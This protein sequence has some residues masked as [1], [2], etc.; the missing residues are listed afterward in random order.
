MNQCV[1]SKCFSGAITLSVGA[2]FITVTC[3]SGGG[4]SCNKSGVTVPNPASFGG[5]IIIYIGMFFTLAAIVVCAIIS[6]R[7]RRLAATGELTKQQGCC[8]ATIQAA[9]AVGFTGFSVA[10][11]GFA[12]CGI[13]CGAVSY[14][15]SVGGGEGVL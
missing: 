9:N 2:L 14:Y 8:S 5:A 10:L 15:L 13:I 1:G 11:L 3:A 6:A 4:Y 7:L 12:I